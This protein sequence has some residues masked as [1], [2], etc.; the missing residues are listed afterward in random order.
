MN[1][2]DVSDKFDQFSK[3]EKVLI[4]ATATILLIV[5][6]YALVI[7]PLHLKVQKSEQQLNSSQALNIKI[8]QQLTANTQALSI[9]AGTAIAAQIETQ[10][11][12]LQM[13]R[14]NLAQR[15]IEV[16]SSSQLEDFTSALV[17][18]PTPVKFQNLQID[19]QLYT[20]EGEPLEET[21]RDLHNC[22]IQLQLQGS[23]LALSSYLSYIESHSIAA[24]WDKFEYQQLQEQRATLN[25]ELH[26][27]CAG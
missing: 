26:L 13:M 5:L 25:L 1:Y 3:R 14:E 23:Y 7:E 8:E 15:K 10:Q 17:H 9:D 24:L 11:Q 12:Q 4:S 21:N 2:S 27:L 19:K 16:L 18:P 20:L 22:H 6:M